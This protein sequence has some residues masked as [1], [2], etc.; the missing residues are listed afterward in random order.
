MSDFIG[1]EFPAK[2]SGIT[3]FGIFAQLENT[4]EGLISYA[5]LDE[6]YRFDEDNYMAV[7][8]R[9]HREIKMGDPIRVVVVGTDP[10]KGKIDFGMAG[11]ENSKK[12]KPERT[13]Q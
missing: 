5:S 4:V 11:E 13:G 1:E 8:E 10:I 3:S 2:V 9:T 6:F 12:D 7:G